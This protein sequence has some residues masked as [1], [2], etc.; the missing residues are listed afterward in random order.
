MPANKISFVDAYNEDVEQV[1][2][3]PIETTPFLGQWG[4]PTNCKPADLSLECI[5]QYGKSYWGAVRLPE[6]SLGFLFASVSEKVYGAERGRKAHSSGKK[7]L[8]HAP[9]RMPI[10]TGR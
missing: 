7:K 1:L 6:V 5:A 3:R 10:T 9:F 2:Q 4:G 8:A